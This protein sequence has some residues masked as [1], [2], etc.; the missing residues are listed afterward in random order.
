MILPYD[1]KEKLKPGN[2]RQTINENSMVMSIVAVVVVVLAIAWC[3]H[4]ADPGQGN[5]G[6]RDAYYINYKTGAISVKSADTRV[7]LAG[8]PDLVQVIYF[9]CNSCHTKKAAYY[10]EYSPQALKALQQMKAQPAGR[11][12][13]PMAAQLQYGD[14]LVSRPTNP[15]HWV[16][17][18]SPQGG[19]IMATRGCPNGKVFEICL[20][21]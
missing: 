2:L 9:S 8:Q 21:S 12:M 10:M 13:A 15:P 11:P 18:A 16:P 20:P 4:V 3:V 6:N 19:K 17:E 1:W 14:Q 5:V 7:P